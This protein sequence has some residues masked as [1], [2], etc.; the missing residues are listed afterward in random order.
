L[1]T[2]NRGYIGTVAAPLFANH[3]HELV[4]LDTDLYERCTYGDAAEGIDRIVTIRKDVRDVQHDDVVG[5][6]A[7]VHFAGLSNDPLGDLNAELT[8]QINHQATVRLATL[9][10]AAGVERFIF[11]SSCSNYGAA[12]DD[13]LA[14]A[15]AFNPV[16]PYGR[17]KVRAELDLAKL[18]DERFS[19]T[20]L[21]SATAYGVSPRLRFD[22]VL[23][24]LTAWAF[25]TGRVHLKSDGSPWRPIVH[26]EDIARA[27]L[28]VIEA[29]RELIHNQAFNVG[30]TAENYRVR[31]L[32]QIVCETVPGST[33]SFAEGAGPDLRNYRV[34][35]DKITRTLPAFKPVW[36]ARRGAKELYDTFVSRGLQLNEFE[37][38]RYQRIGHLKALLADNL[39]DEALRWRTP[40]GLDAAVQSRPQSAASSRL[41]WKSYSPPG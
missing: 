35:C 40:T 19:P 16:T 29:P 6:D 13:M 5:F 17:S 21:R 37:G 41:E 14:E 31:E 12:G 30:R 15:A 26:I 3:G 28:A 1:V 22:L 39:L 8:Y 4:G 23:N 10:K 24:N 9:A 27:F 11:S 25:T 34:N 33:L 38:P 2:G 7:V 18:A 36:D 20:Y 32:A